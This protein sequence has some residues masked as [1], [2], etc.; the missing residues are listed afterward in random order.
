MSH[1]V[2][3][4]FFF[5]V[6]VS[7]VPTHAD[8]EITLHG[9]NNNNR[10]L[11]NKINIFRT[12]SHSDVIFKLKHRQGNIGTLYLVPFYGNNSHLGNRKLNRKLSIRFG[13]DI[14]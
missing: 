8:V 13:Q 4:F 6:G 7:C 3:C 1:N 11:Y 12:V 5:C 2:T 9:N 14:K 10:G